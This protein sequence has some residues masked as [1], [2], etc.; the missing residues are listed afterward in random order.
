M[1]SG[2]LLVGDTADISLRLTKGAFCTSRRYGSAFRCRWGET[3]VLA[4]NAER[5]IDNHLHLQSKYNFKLRLYS[6][7]VLVIRG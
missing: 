7:S 4:L 6:E 3:R 1:R 5:S 2:K